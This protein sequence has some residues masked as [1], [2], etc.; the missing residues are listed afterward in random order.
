MTN[1]EMKERFDAL[2]DE[3]KNGKDVQKMMIFGTGFK[4]LY[5]KAADVHPDLAMATLEFLAAIDFANY[6]TAAEAQEVASR[7]INDDRTL[8]GA[9][10]PSRGA[11]WKP[12][13]LKAFLMS[14]TIP[15]DEKPYYN[16]WALWLTVNVIYSDYAEVIAE[17]AGSKENEKV[18]TV[19]WKMAVK[20]LKDL[21]RTAFIREYF[22]LD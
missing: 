15:L 19:C 18:A 1:I 9:M 17:L 16:W 10:E 21:D 8:T 5:Y 2:Y 13:E 3:M 6:V 12:E 4:K 11:H 7:F 22:E 20:K 14:R